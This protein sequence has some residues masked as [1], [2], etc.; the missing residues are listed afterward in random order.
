PAVGPLQLDAGVV[1][2]DVKPAATLFQIPGYLAVALGT[3]HVEAHGLNARDPLGPE[4][5]G[6]GPPP[7]FVS[8]ADDDPKTQLAQPAGG[9]QPD[10]LVRPG[11][12][13]HLPRSSV[14]H[15][16]LRLGLLLLGNAAKSKGLTRHA[17]PVRER[18]AWCM[19][20]SIPYHLRA[21]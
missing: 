8:A 1:D 11:D 9:L 3:G 15:G 6:P 14:R 16:T 18:R 17:E 2:Q 21:M 4:L 12:E 19:L 13:R 7:A 5:F 20:V 10:A